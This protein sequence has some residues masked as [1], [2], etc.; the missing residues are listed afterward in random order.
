MDDTIART[1]RYSF[2]SLA[3][4]PAFAL[5]VVLT[6]A[7]GIGANSA[8]FSAIDSILVRPLP[9]DEPDRLVSV[10]ETRPETGETV[11]APVRLEEW[12]AGSSSF[13]AITGYFTEDVSETT[14]DTPSRVRWAGVAPKFLEVWR[15]APL[16][17][18]D[19]VDADS[20]QRPTVVWI[21]ERLWRN[22]FD[23]DPDILRRT[24]RLGDPVGFPF[25]IVGV[26]P[27]SF[28]FPNRDV[29]VW[30]PNFT[31]YDLGRSRNGGRYEGVG[32][33]RPGVA[34]EDARA[35]LK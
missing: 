26:L 10:M 21:S 27:A 2:R 20:A 7:L 14:G 1:L 3:R 12:I 19:F 31:N 16:L 29:D 17:G 30:F 24:I 6:L 13:E 9:Y 4:T 28:L 32:R 23:A 11:V 34:I 33:L 18:R 8:V 15:V 22:R 35:D 25:Q 5:A